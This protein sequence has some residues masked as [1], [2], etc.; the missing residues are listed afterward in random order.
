MS[1]RVAIIGMGLVGRS[2]AV[3][4]A[5]AGARV[6]LWDAMD[7]VV[8]TSLSQTRQ[9]VSDM[10]GA[11]LLSETPEAILSR[12]NPCSSLSEALFGADYIQEN[13]PE[14]IEVKHDVLTAIEANAQPDAVIASSTSGLLPSAMFENIASARRC[15]VA[16]PLN[17]P[18][19]IPAVELVPGPATD[20][21]SLH[22]ARMILEETGH[23]VVTLQREIAGFVMNRLQGAVLDEAFR[24]VEQGIVGPEDVDIALRDGLAM[25]WS[26]VG[27]FETIDLNAPGGVFD[28]IDRY[29][30]MYDDLSIGSEGR[31]DWKGPVRDV[32]TA[33]RRARLAVDQIPARTKWR[34][35]RLAEIARNH[36]DKR[37]KS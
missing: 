19:L 28:Y 33:D 14:R 18:H 36:L 37:E 25:R 1:R 23:V 20:A 2:W 24:L 32:V 10:D 35:A 27:P 15:L 9:L 6:A 4:F 22:T 21:A 12:I 29:G 3:D 8:E 16:H 26:V 13:T 7:G 11:G 30:P 31:A 5:R 34:D 17:P